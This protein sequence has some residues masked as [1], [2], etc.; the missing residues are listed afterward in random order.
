MLLDDTLG[1]RQPESC[2][3]ANVLGRV[4]GF[5]DAVKVFRLNADPVVPD[6]EEDGI[7]SVDPGRD[8]D[9]SSLTDGIET[10]QQQVHDDLLEQLMID[11]DRRQPFGQVKGQTYRFLAK[12]HVD[13][14]SDLTSGGADVD[15]A[16]LG[17]LLAGEAEE[18]L[19]NG[20]DVR[21]R[22]PDQSEIL[23]RLPGILGFLLD[24]V[25]AGANAV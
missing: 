23:A 5:E 1:D 22:F 19:H 20:F 10:V 11:G 13:K 8:G 3:L 9:G 6:G 25:E 21:D 24:G 2:S 12:S 17:W 7:C 16:S 14:G 15:H 4:E 18:F